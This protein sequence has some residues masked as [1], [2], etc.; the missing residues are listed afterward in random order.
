M[1]G[2]RSKLKSWKQLKTLRALWAFEGKKVVFTNGVYDILHA[3]H[4]QLLERAKSLGDILVVALNTDAS[5]RRLNKGPERPI[6]R[7]A[8]RAAVAAALACVDVV[9]AF[10]EDTPEKLLSVVKPDI[11]VKGADYKAS[12]IAGA[13]HARKV[14]RVPLKKGYSTT[15]LVRRLRRWPVTKM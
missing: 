6:N 14:A 5:V 12:Q 9:V 8:D 15:E 2:S 13:R 3:G 11:L 10:P 1:A 7:L 4:V